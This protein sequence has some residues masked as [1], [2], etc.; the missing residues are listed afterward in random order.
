MTSNWRWKRHI[1][2]IISGEIRRFYVLYSW[3]S[4]E[5]RRIIGRRPFFSWHYRDN[6]NLIRRVVLIHAC[7]LLR[8]CY[9]FRSKTTNM[10]WPKMRNMIT[11]RSVHLEWILIFKYIYLVQYMPIINSLNRSC[12]PLPFVRFLNLPLHLASLCCVL[13]KTLAA[14][15]IVN[16]ILDL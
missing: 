14:L 6:N 13:D 12:W 4:G 3:K 9:H 2:V 8:Y 10:K 15:S 7:G 5:I 11:H 1:W 16:T